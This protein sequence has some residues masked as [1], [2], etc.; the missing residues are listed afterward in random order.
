MLRDATLSCWGVQAKPFPGFDGGIVDV[1]VG[2]GAFA[3]RR[4]ER[5]GGSGLGLAI[6][7][8]LA[9]ANGGNV[10]LDGADGGGLVATVTLPSR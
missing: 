9:E 8:Q 5:V 2:E 6:V 4:E 3:L 7:Q 10:T 1:V